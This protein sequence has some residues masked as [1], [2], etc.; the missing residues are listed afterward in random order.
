MPKLLTIL[1]PFERSSFSGSSAR[2][3]KL[4]SLN[5]VVRLRRCTELIGRRPKE[6]LLLLDQLLFCQSALFDLALFL[7]A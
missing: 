4:K 5:T 3:H 6:L 7:L 2:Y 1:T